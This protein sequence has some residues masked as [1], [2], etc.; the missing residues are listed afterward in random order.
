MVAIYYVSEVLKAD[1]FNSTHICHHQIEVLQVISF[2]VCRRVEEEEG[3]N[4]KDGS[5]GRLDDEGMQGIEVFFYAFLA[6]S[7]TLTQVQSKLKQ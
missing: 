6:G 1:N 7:F 4:I 2:A 3:K 5:D